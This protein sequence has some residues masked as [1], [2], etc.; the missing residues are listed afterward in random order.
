MKIQL[1]GDRKKVRDTLRHLGRK[2]EERDVIRRLR[3]VRR[4]IR[5]EAENARR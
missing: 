2:L 5:E 4:E 1:S 3:R